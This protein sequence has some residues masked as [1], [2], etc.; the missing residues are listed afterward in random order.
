MTKHPSPSKQSIVMLSSPKGGVGKSSLSR[1]ILVLAAQSGRQVLGLDMD[2]Q[3]TLATW[4]ER[5]ERVRASI[6]AVSHIPVHRA[7]L[8]DW[9]STL[10]M[11]RQS[12]ADFIVI[13]TP[14]SIEINMTAILGLCEDSDFVLV[15]CQ[16]SQDD[17]DSVIP[18]MRHL[19][20]SGAK[21][22]FIINRANIRTRSYA[23]IRSKLLNVGPV[24][25]VEIA[26]AEE[27]SLANGKGLGVMDLSRPKNAEAFGAL[28]S[29]LRQELDL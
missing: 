14:P 9:R 19:K 24:C 18:W 27:I 4:A 17:L 25:P 22:A 7:S 6:P 23:T 28:W 13:D 29:Y 15:P 2:K 8:D 1:N 12:S 16:Q 11:A 26:Q 21:A 3:A 10:K 20:Q 5:R